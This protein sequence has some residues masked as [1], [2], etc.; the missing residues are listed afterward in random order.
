MTKGFIFKVEV[1]FW[2]ITQHFLNR[3][4]KI[5]ILSKMLHCHIFDSTNKNLRLPPVLISFT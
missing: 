2:K 4:Y 3:V 1:C 5:V